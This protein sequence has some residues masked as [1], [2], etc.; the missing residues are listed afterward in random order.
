MAL[1]VIRT[2]ASASAPPRVLG[3]GRGPQTLSKRAAFWLVGLALV[4][5]SGC[6]WAP[7]PAEE[8]ATVIPSIS[9]PSAARAFPD[10]STTGVPDGVVL[11]PYVDTC[12]I[13]TA[14]YVIDAKVVNCSL[15]ILAE[16]VVIS[17]SRIN[18]TVYTDL[19]YSPGSFTISDS[20]VHVGD[21]PGTG[22]GAGNFTARR[23]EVT[24]GRRSVNCYL[25]C[26]LEDSLIHGQYA[27]KTGQDHESGVRMGSNAIIRHNTIACDAPSVGPNSGCSA[28]L[29]GYGDFDIV[30][31]N[32]IDNNLFV[33][34]SGGYCAYGGSSRGK[35]FS[36]GVNNIRFTNNVWQRGT[37]MGAGGRGYVCGHWGPITAFD[38]Q[39]PGNVWIN[40]LWDDGTP[41][42]PSD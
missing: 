15:R 38:A 26:V 12:D 42:D 41:V 39:A 29:T 23:V 31:N 6:G 20:E 30:Q 27:D 18:G 9:S 7:F 17:N 21:W 13:Q 4:S 36:A 11:T 24:G 19:N 37:Q 1:R 35:P 16:G 32:L 28:A 2:G 40:N 5:A 8:P 14:N 22:L 34:G 25:N 3:L 33:A 10:A